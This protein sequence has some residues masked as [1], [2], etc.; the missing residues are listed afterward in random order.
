MKTI[1]IDG[2]KFEGPY[3]LDKDEIPSEAGVILISTEAGEGFKIMCV[4]ESADMKAHIAG[5]DRKGLWKEHAYHGQVDIYIMRTD[6]DD[7]KRAS[8]MDSIVSRREAHLN[9]QR[10]RILEDDW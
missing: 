8:I 2:Y 10:Q 5:S 1:V 9:C 3:I 4:E 7:A 6:C